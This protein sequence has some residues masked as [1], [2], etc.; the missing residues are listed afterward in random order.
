MF[1]CESWWFGW[2]FPQFCKSDM[3]KY[4]YLEVPQR[5]PSTLRQQESTVF[6]ASSETVSIPLN[7]SCHNGHA[8]NNIYQTRSPH[9]L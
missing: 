9:I 4:V 7:A 1:I 6:V 2:Y 5:V 3:S 8:S